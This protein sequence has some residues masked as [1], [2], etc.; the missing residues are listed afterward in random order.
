MLR[1][2]HAHLQTLTYHTES[3]PNPRNGIVLTLGQN[4][5]DMERGGDTKDAREAET[6]SVM[7]H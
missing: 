2:I 1:C 5:S 4:G 6:D 7:G 3:Y